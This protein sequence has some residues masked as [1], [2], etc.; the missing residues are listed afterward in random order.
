ME[1]VN[2][3]ENDN[4]IQLLNLILREITIINENNVTDEVGETNENGSRKASNT[5]INSLREI[6]NK[7]PNITCPICLEE[8]KIDEKCI[9]LPCGNSHRFHSNNDNCPGILEWLSKS[10]TC[11]TCRSEFP[12]ETTNLLERETNP[13]PPRNVV[14][15]V[16]NRPIV[17]MNEL[18]R[19]EEERQLEQAIQESLINS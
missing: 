18:I 15:Q 2:Q 4:R 11:P 1:Q 3:N 13:P 6:E 17:N 7:E 14:F 19:R 9:E 16:I 5:F 8:I 12:S 10:N